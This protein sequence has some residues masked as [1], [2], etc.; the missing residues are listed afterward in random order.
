MPLQIAVNLSPAQF[1]HGDLVGLVHSIL[2]ET[3]LSP[4]RLELEITESAAIQNAEASI[5]ALREEGYPPEAIVN[6]LGL[7]ASYLPARRAAKVDPLTALRDSFRTSF[8]NGLVA[9]GEAARQPAGQQRLQRLQHDA[10]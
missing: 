9:L 2:L 6:L 10:E 5:A 8:P 3:G 1:M 4:G 7:V